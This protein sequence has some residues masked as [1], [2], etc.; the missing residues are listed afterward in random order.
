M[1]NFSFLATDVINNEV[2]NS[3]ELGKEINAILLNGEALST[4]YVIEIIK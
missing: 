3:T 1:N 2:S 4:D